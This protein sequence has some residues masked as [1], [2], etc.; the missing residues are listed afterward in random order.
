MQSE[1]LAHC[2]K[3]GVFPMA[4]NIRA[5]STWLAGSVLDCAIDFNFALSATIQSLAATPPSRQ[6]FFQSPIRIM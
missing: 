2:E 3:R 6:S 4:S 1:R 5:H